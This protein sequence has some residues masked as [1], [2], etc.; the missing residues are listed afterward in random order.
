MFEEILPKGA[1]DTI[2]SL[3]PDIN[4]HHVLK[5]LVYFEDAESDPM[6]PMRP[7]TR[8]W[9]WEEIKLFFESQIGLFEIELGM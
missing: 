4:Y 9:K 5:S 7:D 6:P 1:I 3:L 2:P 8:G